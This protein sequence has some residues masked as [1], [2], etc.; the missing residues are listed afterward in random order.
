MFDNP[1]P[2]VLVKPEA[3]LTNLRPIPII[4]LFLSF[5]TITPLTIIIYYILT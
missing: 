4:T 5:E 1:D 2:F 3:C